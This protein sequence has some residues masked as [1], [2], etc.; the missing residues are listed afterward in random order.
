VIL[1]NSISSVKYLKLSV[2]GFKNMQR[3]YGVAVFNDEEFQILMSKLSKECY[4]LVDIFKRIFREV[5]GLKCARGSMIYEGASYPLLYISIELDDGTRYIFEIFL[6]SI[7][8][9]ANTNALDLV[10][11]LNK[12]AEICI[13]DKLRKPRGRLIGID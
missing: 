10:K 12:L 13:G 6:K 11:V 1:E 2:Y 5:K 8:A 7:C 3:S 4:E 9:E